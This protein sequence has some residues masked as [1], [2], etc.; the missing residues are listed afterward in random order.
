MSLT[1]GRKRGRPILLDRE[2]VVST[3]ARLLATAGVAGFSMR[4]L[5][6]ELGVSTAAVYH[7]FPT[8][9]ELFF[10]VLSA[11]ADELDRPPLPSDPRE[12]LVA[13]VVYLIDTLHQLP[14]VL[15]ILVT[16]ETFGRAAM[17]ILDEFVQA[18]HEL[19]ADDEKA[20]YVYGVMWR[21]VLGELMTRRAADERARATV[22]AGRPPRHWTDTAT[23]E[24]LAD[25]PNV[26]RV[27]PQWS[28]SIARHDTTTATRDMLDGLLPIGVE[29]I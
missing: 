4:G 28:R 1:A 7:H 3:T 19:G 6:R 13:V 8:R 24:M 2:A 14:W 27:L 21:F 29:N 16:G 26:V 23:A 9:S 15:D 10:A 20:I 25:F 11:R 17:W 5:A 22:A 18:A 12:R